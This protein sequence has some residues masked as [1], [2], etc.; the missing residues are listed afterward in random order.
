VI[1]YMLGGGLARS[2]EIL[3]IRFINIVNRGIRNILAY[4]RII[5]FIV[6]YHKGFRQTGEAKVIHRYLP[7]EV[8]E[9]LV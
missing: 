4:N 8:G 3:G 6:L 5:C 7:R 2:T 1:I 9:L